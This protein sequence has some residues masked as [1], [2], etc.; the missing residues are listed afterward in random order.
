MTIQEKLKSLNA[1]GEALEWV[2]AKSL[3]VAWQTCPRADWMLWLAAKAKVKNQAIVLAAC[4]CAATTLKYAPK[5]EKHQA[6]C[7]RI[8]RAW[9]R[10]RATIEQVWDARNGCYD[11][12]S[13]ASDSSAADTAAAAAADT[14]YATI[15]AADAAY[16][17]AYTRAEV[18]KHMAVL[19][20]KR[21]PLAMIKRALARL[22]FD[23]LSGIEE[24]P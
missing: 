15:N 3:T 4:D 14:A 18:H 10:D 17:A 6:K 19:I 24:K 21:I 8:T 1:C 13:T 20:R 22:F 2:G 11:A 5:G 23:P 12:A 7:I 9:L 16:A